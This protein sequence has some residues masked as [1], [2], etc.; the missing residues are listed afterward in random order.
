M[1]EHAS[2][3]GKGKPARRKRGFER[4][5]TLLTAR[6]RKVGESRGFAVTRLLTHWPDIAGEQIAAIARPVDVK[7]GREGLG[8]TLTVLTTGAQAPMLEM[9]KEQLR[10][11]VNAVYGYA[12]IARVRIT[13]T[14]PTGFA[15][16]QA[17]FTPAPK[18]KPGPNPETKAKARKT[19]APV[20]DDRLR[21]ALEALGQNILSRQ[22]TRKG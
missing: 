1:T 19:A 9:Q 3:K 15:E 5:A 14:A 6:I 16:G 20:K 12:A 10:D 2:N 4:T 13:Q 17:Q 22:E 7:Y 18:A 11:K 8:A 21:A